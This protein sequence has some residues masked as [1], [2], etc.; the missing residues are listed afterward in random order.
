LNEENENE[1]V[2]FK[3]NKH[4][5]KTT[6]CLDPNE[7][8]SLKSLKNFINK[9]KNHNKDPKKLEAAMKLYQEEME[10]L[11]SLNDDVEGRIYQLKKEQEAQSQIYKRNRQAKLEHDKNYYT[12]LLEKYEEGSSKHGEILG[13]VSWVE[14]QIASLEA[15]EE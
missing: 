12:G 13:L 15:G 5:E 14:G 10:F 2:K 6:D 9:E 11:S 8:D 3:H 1:H 7:N 4:I